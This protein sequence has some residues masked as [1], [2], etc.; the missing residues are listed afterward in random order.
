MTGAITRGKIIRADLAL[1]DGKTATYTRPDATGGT[2][3]GVPVGDAVDVLQVYG[4]GT[5]RTD[6]AIQAAVDYLGS[7]V[8]TLVFAPGTWTIAASVTVPSTLPCFVP[9]GCIFSVNNGITLTFSGDVVIEY[10]ASWTSGAGTVTIGPT[11]G[12]LPAT[13]A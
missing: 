9:A 4:A 3:T 13:W 1:Y 5:A 11:H 10:P 8:A 2:V 12:L 6:A 7:T